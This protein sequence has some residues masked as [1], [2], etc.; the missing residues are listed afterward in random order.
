MQNR[1]L[2]D[3]HHPISDIFTKAIT[4]IDYE[5]FKLSAEQIEHFQEYGYLTNVK[6]FESEQVDILRKE[7]AEIADPAHPK[8]DLFYEFHNNQSTDPE[9]V[10][11][12]SLGHWRITQGFHDALWNPAFTKPASQLLGIKLFVFGTTNCFVNPLDTVG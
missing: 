7:L 6:I 10:L 4:Q 2:A 12:H 3:Y 5:P 11:F 9:T 1:D 8:H